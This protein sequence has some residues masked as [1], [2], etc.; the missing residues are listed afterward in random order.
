MNRGDLK[1]TPVGGDQ[2]G[3]AGA[4]L[5]RCRQVGLMYGT[6]ANAVV[7]VREVSCDVVRRAR[8]AIT[9]PS[10]SGKSSLLHLMAGLELPTAGTIDG[11]LA[12]GRRPDPRAVGLVFQSPSLIP[13]L[14]VGENVALPLILAGTPARQARGAADDA[15]AALGIGW[16]GQKLPEELSGGQ[17]QRAAIARVLACRPS[18]ILADE[19]TGQLDHQTAG[20]I[21][22]VLIQAA[23]S[24]GAALLVTTHDPVIA[25]LLD[26]NWHM[27]DGT[28]TG[29]NELETA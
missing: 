14:D 1:S 23:D 29:P 27:H 28:L 21:M 22:Q 26:R 16:L 18:L 10:G 7:A 20:R 3:T 19:P 13:A 11:T 5:L 4:P 15:L 6:G 17:A 2:P 9:G 25:G 24:L 12:A 8:V